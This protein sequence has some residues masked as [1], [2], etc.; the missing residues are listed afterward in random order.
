MQRA[1]WEGVVRD[2]TGGEEG[3]SSLALTRGSDVTN[4]EA[5]G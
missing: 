3:I 5:Q 4:V 1:S 2:S